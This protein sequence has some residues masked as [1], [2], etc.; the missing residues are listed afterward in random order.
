M[1]KQFAV[2]LL[3]FIF[4]LLSAASFHAATRTV[5]TIADNGAL[6]ACTAAANDC[7]LRGAVS[8]SVTDDIINFSPALNYQTIT[9]GS[10]ITITQGISINGP[11]ADLLRISGRDSYRHFYINGG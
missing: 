11:G 8:V 6:T 1:K 9:L 2:S 7:S 4:V 10:E 5:D 3:G